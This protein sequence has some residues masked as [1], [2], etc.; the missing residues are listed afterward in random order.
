MNAEVRDDRVHKYLAI[1]VLAVIFILSLFTGGCAATAPAAATPASP[2]TSIPVTTSPSPSIATPAPPS[3]NIEVAPASEFSEAGKILYGQN[4][5]MCH[6]A[7]GQGG[8]GPALIG[9]G[10]NLGRY[11][12]AQMLFDFVSTQMPLGKGESL[13]KAVYLR[14]VVF[15]LVQNGFAGPSTEI[16][17]DKLD[18]I[19]FTQ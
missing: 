2:A 13:S 19:K 6:G 15:L 12:N 1:V 3:S 10:S 18:A 17:A 11:G 7:D 9:S 5:A 16:S 4:C 8:G 14:L